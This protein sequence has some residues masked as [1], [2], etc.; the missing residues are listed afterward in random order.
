M[1]RENLEQIIRACAEVAGDQE[2]VVV[3]SQA[4]LGSFPQA[5]AAMLISAE[6]DVYPRNDRSQADRIDS[7]LGELTRF[8][9]EFDF[10]AQL[11]GPETAKAPDGWEDRLVAL[12]NENT[13]GATGWCLEPHDLVLS[14]LVRAENKDREFA[15]HAL[16]FGL[17]S[18]GTLKQRVPSMPIAEAHKTFL[19][20]A[21]LDAIAAAAQMQVP[22]G[23]HTVPLHNAAANPG[24]WVDGY[25]R[26][27]RT[28]K[29]YWRDA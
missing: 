2:I 23:R 20:R 9:A 13:G 17:V 8:H 19:A 1:R 26:N 12:S 4:I 16:A 7:A 29:G 24:R 5:P 21:L 27:G 3:G 6:A 14:K 11:V 28:V 10:Y 22:G 15:K 18:P 25:S